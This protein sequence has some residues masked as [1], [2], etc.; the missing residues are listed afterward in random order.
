MSRSKIGRKR[1][2]R[3]FV[4]LLVG[5]TV[6]ACFAAAEGLMRCYVWA[7]GWTSNC[8]SAE[9]DL[10][11]AHRERGYDLRPNFRLRSGVFRMSINSDGFRGPEI[12]LPAS[13]P[14]TGPETEP[15]PLRI[16]VLGGSSVF[17]YLV[18]DGEEACRILESQLSQG[19]RKTEVLNAGVPGYNL[20]QTSS[21]YTERVAPFKPDLVILYLG[22]NDLPYVTSET[23]AAAH[24]RV[25]D[26]QVASSWQ[27]TSGGSVFL[28]FMNSRLGIGGRGEPQRHW[29]SVPTVA[30]E[31][32]FGDNIRAL[33]EEARRDGAKVVLCVQALAAH[34]PVDPS[35]REFLPQS[36]ES[37]EASLRLAEWLQK[38]LT[39]LSVE[40][41]TSLLDAYGTIPGTAEFLGDDVHLTRTGEH[42][43]AQLWAEAIDAWFYELD[44][45]KREL[46]IGGLEPRR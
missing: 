7:R 20:F 6:L 9:T 26:A 11:V 33:V 16:A 21:R 40:L 32:Q 38:I 12:Q 43:L 34:D 36:T 1:R 3:L 24:F 27:R 19:P 4:V 35:L 15:R 22:Y 28:S 2:R 13:E 29:S 25:R 14:K 39:D 18:N 23:P 44:S 17:G 46:F 41:E 31:R 45:P 37:L 30:G 8:Y 10:F 42:R 5:L